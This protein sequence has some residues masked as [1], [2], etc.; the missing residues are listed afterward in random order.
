MGVMIYKNKSYMLEFSMALFSLLHGSLLLSDHSVFNVLGA[1]CKLIN[2]L[3]SSE[4]FSIRQEH[5]LAIK[6]AVSLSR[7]LASGGVKQN[8]SWLSQIFKQ[9]KGPGV[10]FID[11]HLLLKDFPLDGARLPT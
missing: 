5:P 3:W 7:G 9:W 6:E 8:L 2:S 10:L 4:Y 1:Y 11:K